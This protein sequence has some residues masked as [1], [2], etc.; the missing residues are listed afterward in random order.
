MLGVC[1]LGQLIYPM[2]FP[3]CRSFL[4][5]NLDFYEV[6][7][8]DAPSY[9]ELCL[10][11]APLRILSTLVRSQQISPKTNVSVFH[12]SFTLQNKALEISLN[13]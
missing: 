11:M 13:R 2:I 1:I 8:M 7:F 12:L 5:L 4:F 3:Y 6:L 9:F 10:P